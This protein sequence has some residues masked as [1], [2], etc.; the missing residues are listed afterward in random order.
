M[1]EEKESTTTNLTDMI[2][3]EDV[4]PIELQPDKR[5]QQRPAIIIAEDDD[6]IRDYLTKELSEDYDIHSCTNGREAL[7][8][9]YRTHPDIIISDVMKPE[10]DGNT[11]CT[12]LK[13]NPQTNHLPVILL[14][15]KNRDED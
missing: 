5:L 10:M 6:E 3:T 7:A 11:L 9:V 1:I 2:D 14:T 8:E 4:P 15:A 12:Q 13:L